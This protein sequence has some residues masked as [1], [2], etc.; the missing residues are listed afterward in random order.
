MARTRAFVLFV[1]VLLVLSGCK[2]FFKLNAFSSLDKAAVRSE[3][4]PGFGGLVNLQSDLKSQA[5][6]NALKGDPGKWPRS[7]VT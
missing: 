6:V 5:I 1:A 3:Q 2:A 4:V 7:W